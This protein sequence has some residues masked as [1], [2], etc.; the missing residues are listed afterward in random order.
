MTSNAMSAGFME[1]GGELH[2][3]MDSS[4]HANMGGGGIPMQQMPNNA[5]QK[6]QFSGSSGMSGGHG[7]TNQFM[8]NQFNHQVCLCRCVPI[9]FTKFLELIKHRKFLISN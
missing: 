6:T 1:N 5:S 8:N 3:F 9:I 2:E 7:S 4:A